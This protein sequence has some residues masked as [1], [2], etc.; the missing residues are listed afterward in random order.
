MRHIVALILVLVSIPAAAA[1]AQEDCN[2][3][4]RARIAE[5]KDTQFRVLVNFI[6]PE[7]YEAMDD[8]TRVA[9]NKKLQWN[10]IKRAGWREDDSHAIAR[11]AFTPA[12][13]AS[14]S[15]R[16][17]ENAIK[18]KTVSCVQEDIPVPAE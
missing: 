1:M 7:G 11:F 13:S 17:I 15:P 12:L 6:T 16:E 9:T 8:M 5:G 2:A 4:I 10:F 3:A 14:M 18:D